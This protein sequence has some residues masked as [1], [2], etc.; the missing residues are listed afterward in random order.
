V[1]AQRLSVVQAT[2]RS[3]LTPVIAELN[4][5]SRAGNGEAKHLLE[6]LAQ[7]AGAPQ[8]AGA[9]FRIAEMVRD[10]LG[11]PAL[12]GQ[13]LLD[14]AAA[15]TA[16]LYAPKAL[17]AALPLLPDRHDSIAAVLDTR[18]ATSPY[19]RAYHGEASV[20]YVAAE[21]S[22]AGELGVEVARAAATGASGLRFAIPVPGVRGPQ[23]E[24][25]AAQPAGAPVVRPPTTPRPGARPAA[26]NTDRDRPNAPDRP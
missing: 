19:T 5:L 21:D 7:A 24:E 22:L 2:Q 17:V 9:R 4:E 16:S 14:A 13:L 20:A 23:L 6:L 10:S 11:A 26:G 25:P 8:G 15:D 18:Y 12:A 3:D 1:R